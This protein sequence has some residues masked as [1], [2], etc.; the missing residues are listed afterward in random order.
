MSQLFKGNR[1]LKGIFPSDFDLGQ[2]QS[3][4]SDG[5]AYTL[6]YAI[7]DE[8]QVKRFEVRMRDGM[9]YSFSYGIL[10]VFI[11]ENS[12]LLFIRA[13]EL[14]VGIKGV[15]LDPIHHYLNLEQLLWLQYS[16]GKNSE[17]QEQQPFIQEI[18]VRG[19]TTSTILN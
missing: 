6:C 11:L 2:E 13:H 1:N 9:C 5:S 7:E 17:G 3:A 4:P 14:L 18:W 19:E 15:N 10:P 12:G 16:S 8:Q